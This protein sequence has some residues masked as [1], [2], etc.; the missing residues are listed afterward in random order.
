MGFEM[1]FV[2]VIIVSV[3]YGRPA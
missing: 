2:F 3:C 1:C